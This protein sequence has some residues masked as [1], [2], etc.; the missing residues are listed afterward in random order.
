MLDYPSVSEAL[1]FWIR[2]IAWGVFF[3]RNSAAVNVVVIVSYPPQ[4]LTCFFLVPGVV[5][6]FKMKTHCWKI[7]VLNSN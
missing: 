5:W 2:K 7:Q 4:G 3:S 6:S 1:D